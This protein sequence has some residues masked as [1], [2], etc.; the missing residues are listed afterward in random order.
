[1]GEGCAVQDAA[2]GR[3]EVTKVH[4]GHSTMLG[5]SCGYGS[6]KGERDIVVSANTFFREIDKRHRCHH[7]VLTRY[8]HG[9]AGNPD[10]DPTLLDM[11]D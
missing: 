10:P 3:L 8:P 5:A 7:C 4:I 6:M 1:M 2:Q 9:G 11:E